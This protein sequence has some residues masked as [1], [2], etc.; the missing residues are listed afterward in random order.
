MNL[1][2]SEKIFHEVNLYIQCL[3]IYCGPMKQCMYMYMGILCV[4]TV[5]PDVSF[6][7]CHVSAKCQ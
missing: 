6:S 3:H 2:Y 7:D 5:D 4:Q 1:Q